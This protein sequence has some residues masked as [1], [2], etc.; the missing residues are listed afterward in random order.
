MMTLELVVT[1]MGQMGMVRKKAKILTGFTDMA[2]AGQEEEAG[3]VDVVLEELGE[4]A[5]MGL[6]DP[7]DL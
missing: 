7:D 4:E 5:H 2:L 1:L 6:D 3:W